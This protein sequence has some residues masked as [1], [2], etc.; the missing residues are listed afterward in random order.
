MGCR[1]VG[2]TG[3]PIKCKVCREEFGYDDVIDYKAGAISIMG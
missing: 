3:G 1:A 2:I